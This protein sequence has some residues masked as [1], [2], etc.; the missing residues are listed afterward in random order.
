MSDLLQEVGISY[1]FKPDGGALKEFRYGRKHLASEKQSS[2]RVYCFNERDLE[3]LLKHWNRDKR[4]NY[5]K[6]Q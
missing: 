2:E 5:W 3:T 6:E 4:W 1:S